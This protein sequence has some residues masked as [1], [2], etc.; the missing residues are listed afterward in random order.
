[1]VS[2][3]NTYFRQN[4]IFK[5]TKTMKPTFLLLLSVILIQSCNAPTNWNQYLGP[6][7]NATVQEA[8]ILKS[9]G[10]NGPKELWSFD[11]GEGYGGVSIYN[12]EV[13]V[14]DREK[15]VKDILRCIDFT[16]GEELWSYSYEAEGELSFPGSRAVPTVDENYIWSVGPHGDFY[17]F[18]KESHLPVWHHQL[19]EK[20]DPKLSPWGYSQSPLLHNELII[21][22]P[23]GTAGVVAFKKESGEIVWESRALTGSS[24]HSSPTL[25]DFGG[26]KQVIMISPYDRSDSTKIHEVASFSAETGEELWSYDGLKSFG[27][28][29]PPAVIGENRL[30]FTDCSYNG[31]YGPV[32]ILLE[33]KNTENGFELEEIFFTE[34]AGCKMHPGVLFE[35]HIYVNST[36]RPNQMQCLNMQGE[37]IWEYDSTSN[38]EMGALL[39]IDDLMISQNGKNGDIHLIEPSTEGYKELGKASFFDSKKSQAWAPIAYYDGKILVRDMEKMVCVDLRELGE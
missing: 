2:K 39:L 6:N 28:I 23:H 13:F 18:D 34:E 30:L 24:F 5:T 37:A 35:D 3:K 22:A 36:G 26:I 4:S 1:L 16:T 27:T 38:F 25:A 21:A 33:V 10:E 15:G 12:D 20:Y 14:L 11:L 29:T 17:C 7:R 9:W 8:D 32:S 19:K 31:K